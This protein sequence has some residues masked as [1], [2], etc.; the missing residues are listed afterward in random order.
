[1]V[2]FVVK[3]DYVFSALGMIISVLSPF[4]VGVAIAFVLNHPYK[5][6]ERRFLRLFRGKSGAAKICSL[7]SV[8][9]MFSLALFSVFGFVIPQLIDSI[10]ELIQNTEKYSSAIDAFFISALKYFRLD[11]YDPGDYVRQFMIYLNQYSSS[12][13]GQLV[14]FGANVFKMVTNAVFGFII[15]A[16]ILIDKRKIKEQTAKFFTANFKPEIN[17]KIGWITG[18]IV[19]TFTK[20]VSGQITE[21]CILGVLCFIG[22]N[23][24]GFEYALLISVIVAITNLI[25]IIGVFIGIIPAVF[26]LLAISPMKALWYVIFI[27]I[28]QQIEGN[29]IYPRVVGHSIG[30]SPLWVFAAIIAGG[31]LFGIVGMLVAVPVTSVIYQ[32]VRKD[33]YKKLGNNQ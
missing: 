25:P 4:F 30:L 27:I 21:A 6:L 24:F 31:G 15:S 12:I 17:R 1:M 33:T 28:L 13:L 19:D 16:Y 11:S 23:I 14:S 29:F 18:M 3:I 32:L 10:A 2:L 9:A 5:I 8:Y 20:F 22:M 7:I 26:L